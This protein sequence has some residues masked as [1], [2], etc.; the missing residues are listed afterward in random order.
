MAH[1]Q[2]RPIGSRDPSVYT[3]TWCLR[4]D[5]RLRSDFY[6]SPRYG[7]THCCA[8]HAES[9]ELQPGAGGR[10]CVNG[11]KG[12]YCLGQIRLCGVSCFP[13]ELV[14]K[15]GR[16]ILRV[17]ARDGLLNDIELVRLVVLG[18]GLLFI[19]I[20]NSRQIITKSRIISDD[21]LD[22][23]IMEQRHSITPMDCLRISTA[24]FYSEEDSP[25]AA[26][27]AVCA[28]GTLGAFLAVLIFFPHNSPSAVPSPV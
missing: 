22:Y 5:F 8:G 15:F 10:N 13:L 14:R 17:Y 6:E 7:C 4:N 26:I 11:D 25:P 19:H 16:P 28:M 1:L 2:A 21:V 27:V 23:S 18:R 9:Y 12:R 24:H 3:H 20:I